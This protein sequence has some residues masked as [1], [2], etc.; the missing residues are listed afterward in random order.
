MNNCP[1]GAKIAKPKRS[2]SLLALGKPIDAKTIDPS[3]K[4]RAKKLV[5]SSYPTS[6]CTCQSSP[7]E[8]RITRYQRQP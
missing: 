2:V 6:S 1:N 5:P 8:L 7:P 3:R 4:A